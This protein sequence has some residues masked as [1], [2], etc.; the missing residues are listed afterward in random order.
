[1]YS[2]CVRSAMLHASETWPLT[3]PNLQRLK[4]NDNAMVRQMCNVKL[5]DMANTSSEELRGKLAIVDL[6][7]ILKERRLRWY[8]HVQ[9]S[10]GAIKTASEMQVVGKRGRGRPKL[11]WKQ[12]TEKDSR[13]WGV[14]DIDP[15]DRRSLRS[16]IHAASQTSGKGP[17]DVDFA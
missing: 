17:A 13:E 6:E 10:Q 11:T 5:K 14:S 4:R 1:M 8:G 2:T 15:H 16:A 3:S 9:R 7:V 12:L